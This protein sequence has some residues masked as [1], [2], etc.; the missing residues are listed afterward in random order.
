MKTTN[1]VIVTGLSGSGKSTALRALEDAGY[2]CIDNLPVILLPR[3]L[4]L[5]SEFG[6][7]SIRLG[8]VMDLREK[9]FVERFPAVFT[10]LKERKYHIEMLFLQASDETLIQRFS[11][12]RRQHPIAGTYSLLN[13]LQLERA[14]LEPVRSL[15]DR[16]LDTSH[17]NIHELRKV[18]TQ[19][20][21]PRATADQMNIQLLSFGYKYGIPHEADLVMD[22]RFLPNP[23]Y[24]SHLRNKNGTDPEV[25]EY[26][27][28]RE[29]ALSFLNKFHELLMLLIP[30]YRKEGK[31]HLTLA[32]GC[33]G[34]RHRSVAVV[35][36]FY[37]RLKKENIQV[38]LQFR[39]I[40]QE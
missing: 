22:V 24:L 21:S 10:H 23:F 7:Q 2:F 14:R 19:S 35:T 20:Y 6:T 1:I 16:I 40:K 26:V 8:L 9:D 37:E 11:Q 4:D 5:G 28:N 12:T 36:A 33:T 13:K 18:I 27:L 3:L 39:D 32:I 15:A 34:G 29:D 30:L 31:S 25:A 38:S 17:Y